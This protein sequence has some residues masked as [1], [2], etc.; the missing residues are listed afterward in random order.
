MDDLLVTAGVKA[1]YELAIDFVKERIKKIF[2]SGEATPP[3]TN[4]IPTIFLCYTDCDK[5]IADKIYARLKNTNLQV[6]YSEK[7]GEG[8]ENRN[9]VV[10][11]GLCSCNLFVALIT[12]NYLKSDFAKQELGI[13]NFLS[14]ESFSEAFKKRTNKLKRCPTIMPLVDL[15]LKERPKEIGCFIVSEKLFEKV[16]VEKMQTNKGISVYS[17]ILSA[18]MKVAPNETNSA[19]DE[20]VQNYEQVTNSSEANEIA[21][22]L[23]GL[24]EY[25]PNKIKVNIL[26]VYFKHKKKKK[27]NRIEYDQN[28]VACFNRWH[29]DL[30]SKTKFNLP[31]TA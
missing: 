2:K 20:L 13:A 16:N 29:K 8:G 18:F 28:I 10:F 24:E 31:P 22:S 1:T 21:Y 23:V 19:I 3:L 15:N 6:F 9:E 26:R 11:N 30:K 27:D 25:L 12:G 17:R 5:Q 7:K 14:S 4:V